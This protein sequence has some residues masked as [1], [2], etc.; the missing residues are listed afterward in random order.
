MKIEPKHAAAITYRKEAQRLMFRLVDD[1]T[2][3]LRTN[4]VAADHV[5]KLE[6]HG[7]ITKTDSLFGM[8]HNYALYSPTPE[9]IAW[10]A[11]ERARR[12]ANRALS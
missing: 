3:T 11:E 10:V 9:G 1:P 6:L 4:Y 5:I 2:Q 12:A 8:S 7:L